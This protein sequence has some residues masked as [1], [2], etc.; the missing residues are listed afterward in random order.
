MS[1]GIRL[2]G[3]R[4]REPH[5]D[6]DPFGGEALLS[7]AP[8]KIGCRTLPYDGCMTNPIEAARSLVK[9]LT[10]GRAG[11]ALLALVLFGEVFAVRVLGMSLLDAASHAGTSG[12]TLVVGAI[13]LGL[14]LVLMPLGTLLMRLGCQAGLFELGKIVEFFE[15]TGRVTGIVEKVFQAGPP[16]SALV[17][18]WRHSERLLRRAVDGSSA[19]LELQKR[20][21]N[22]AREESALSDVC[23]GSFLIGMLDLVTV[24]SQSL[25]AHGW[26]ALGT[27]VGGFVAKLVALATVCAVLVRGLWVPERFDLEEDLVRALSPLSHPEPPAAPVAEMRPGD[28]CDPSHGLPTDKGWVELRHRARHHDEAPRDAARLTNLQACKVVLPRTMT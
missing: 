5:D 20:R 4:R 21:E 11:L 26:G 6:D 14:F 7:G 1:K 22:F 3:P 13:G 9:L 15:P 23:L 25:V 10:S 27:G 18:S 28:E 2:G 8:D 19:A 24:G 17:R 16:M 12:P